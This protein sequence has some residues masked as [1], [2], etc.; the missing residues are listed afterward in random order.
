MKAWSVLGLGALFLVTACDGITIGGPASS[1]PDPATSGDDAV[2]ETAIAGANQNDRSSGKDGEELQT[3]AMVVS[4]SGRFIVMQ[5]NTVTLVYDVGAAT[6]HELSAALLR[7][8][9]AKGSDTIFAYVA[10]GTIQAIDLATR[11]VRWSAP[12]TNGGSL[13]R[14]SDDDRALL[15]GEARAIRVLAAATGA[16]RST[17][18][19]SAA[20]SYA[21]FVPG[22]ARALVVTP[23]LWHDGGPHTAVVDVDLSGSRAASSVDVPNCEA[24]IVVTPSGAR[25][26]L[27]PTYCSPGAQ[28]VPGEV[29]TNPDPVSVLELASG[30]ATFN[31]NLPGF[32]PVVM[33]KDGARLVAY[34]DVKRMDPKMFADPKQVPWKDGQRYHLMTID[35]AT[36]AFALAPIGNAIPRFAMTNDGRGLLVDASAKVTSRTVAAA[37]ASVSIGPDGV[38]GSVETNL[39]VFGSASAFGTFDLATQTFSSFSGPTAPLDRFVQLGSRYVLTLGKRADGLGGTPYLIDLQ[40]R[41]TWQ[42]QGNFGSGVRDVGLAADGVTAHVRLRLPANVH[43][44]GFY[45]RE[46]LCS[47]TTGE[48]GVSLT[49][50]YEASV[51]FALVPPPPPPS[52]PAPPTPVDE[53]PGGHDCY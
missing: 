35:P 52:V 25:A 18:P 29:W 32:G 8:A 48:C 26:F 20:P 19:V 51:P 28:A 15:L 11:A 46:G 38:S 39:D 5:R 47:S 2:D 45:S 53:C 24:P 30:A 23:T 10:G 34:L 22:Q 14:I 27:S 50:T 3:G 37:R 17:T 41:A 36:L 12:A 42:L 21:A 40:A 9:F 31:R 7:V 1:A 43:D 49:A 44:G 6:Y 4:P 33:S 13:L 16:V